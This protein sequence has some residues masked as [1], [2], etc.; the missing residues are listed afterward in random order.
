MG[1]HGQPVLGM[2]SCQEYSDE[3]RCGTSWNAREWFV[4]RKADVQMSEDN[5]LLPNVKMA[6]RPGSRFSVETGSM[7]WKRPGPTIRW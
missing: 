5:A 6:S 4:A 7:T 3:D 1:E 2:K